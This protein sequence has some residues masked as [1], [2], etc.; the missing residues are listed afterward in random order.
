MKKLLLF[1]AVCLIAP[2]LTFANTTGSLNPVESLSAS[3]DH[4]KIK[5]KVML[6]LGNP[7]KNCIHRWPIC[8]VLIYPY[9]SYG[10]RD[11]VPAVIEVYDEELIISILKDDIES[12][13]SPEVSSHLIDRNSVCFGAGVDFPDELID[14]IKSSSVT[15]IDAKQTYML[16]SDVKSVYI[17]V[18]L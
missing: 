12:L 10:N 16:T 6:N 3:S 8:S 13:D 11:S 18:P 14:S 15:G 17:H 1:F 2:N 4:P 5:Y 7:R 9:T